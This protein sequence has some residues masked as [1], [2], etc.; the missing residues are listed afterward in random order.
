MTLNIGIIDPHID[1]VMWVHEGPGQQR[2][3]LADPVPG[4]LIQS[5]QTYLLS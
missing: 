5:N 1:N 2:H 3:S 4:L